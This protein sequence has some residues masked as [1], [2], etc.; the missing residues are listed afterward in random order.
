MSELTCPKCKT[1]TLRPA[2]RGGTPVI[3]CYQ[4]HG[5]W[6]TVEEAEAL[7]LGGTLLDPYSMLPQKAG[8]DAI[9]GL[10][11]EGHGLMTRAKVDLEDAFYLERCA[12]C[13]G[14][15]F[16]SGEWQKLASSHLVHHLRDLWDP[17]WHR[18]MRAERIE[19]GH[20]ERVVELIGEPL[21][22]EIDRLVGSLE[23]HAERREAVGYLKQ[24]LGF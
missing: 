24:K 8:G 9:T 2:G 22:A 20:R 14:I 19:R 16:D 15:W 6:V 21:V 23:G 4:C 1:V 12:R 10:C 3:R 13:G 17:E 7:A 18:R 11:P 5:M